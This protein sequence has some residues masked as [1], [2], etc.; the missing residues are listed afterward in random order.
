MCVE[1]FAPANKSDMC[2][3]ELIPKVRGRVQF[4]RKQSMDAFE[5]LGCRGAPLLLEL[6]FELLHDTTDQ[7]FENDVVGLL[8]LGEGVL[9]MPLYGASFSAE[10]LIEESVGS[11]VAGVEV[12][13]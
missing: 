7:A 10:K 3:V 5:L 2:S 13:G 6:P 11:E 12:S 8:D 4:A 1:T 9:L